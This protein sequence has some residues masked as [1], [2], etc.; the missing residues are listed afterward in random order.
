MARAPFIFLGADTQEG[1]R[2]QEHGTKFFEMEQSRKRREVAC[3]PHRG[4]KL[5]AILALDNSLVNLIVVTLESVA[6][7]VVDED[8]V[9]LVSE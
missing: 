8:C 4:G 5:G 3:G 1:F 7:S 9:S 6:Q 2:E